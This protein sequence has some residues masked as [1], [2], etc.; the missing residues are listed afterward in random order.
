MTESELR[1]NYVETARNYIGAVEG[2][3]RH[4]R[5]VNVYN[6]HT[7]L[8]RGYALKYTDA[9]CAG[10]VSA[11]A[12]MAGVADVV[13]LEVSAPQM[14]ANA[15]SMGIWVEDDAYTPTP[16]DIIAYDWED[17]GKGDNTGSPDHVGVVA[18][19]SGGSITVIEGNKNDAVEYRTIALNGRYI[20]GYIVPDY[21]SIAAQE[22]TQRELDCTWAVERGLIQGYGG[23]EYGWDEPVTRGQLASIMR[24]L[25]EMVGGDG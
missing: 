16:G 2:T 1:E 14:V 15:Q 5:I 21:A 19:V 12:I 25:A 17:T 22:P 20:R 7:P 11:W 4:E 24:R 13:P 10:A 6:A 8:A 18:Q 3:A 23:G 9:W